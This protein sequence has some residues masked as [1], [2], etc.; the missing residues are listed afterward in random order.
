MSVVRNKKE[1]TPKDMHV[2]ISIDG[3]RERGNFILSNL[4]TWNILKLARMKLVFSS[5]RKGTNEEV[6]L[7][8]QKHMAS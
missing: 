3:E 5:I 2:Y 1:V 4:S 6:A 8:L 7:F